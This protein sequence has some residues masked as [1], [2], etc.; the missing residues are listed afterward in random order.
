MLCVPISVEVVHPPP[1]ARADRL[2]PSR[3]PKT[4]SCGAV[5]AVCNSATGAR[6]QRP[7][8]GLRT[9]DCPG[10]PFADSSGSQS[11]L[12]NVDEQQAREA[13]AGDPFLANGV[14]ELEEVRLWNV[15][16][17]ELTG[18]APDASI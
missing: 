8:H 16:V 3:G 17:D 6:S 7:R 14:F 1:S 13:I 9:H 10:G 18:E 2:S 4:M 12:E 15:F 11:L 5:P